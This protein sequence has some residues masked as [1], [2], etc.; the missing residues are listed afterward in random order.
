MLGNCRLQP[1]EGSHSANQVR[2]GGGKQEHRSERL[3]PLISVFKSNIKKQHGIFRDLQMMLEAPGNCWNSLQTA[4]ATDLRDEPLVRI[5]PASLACRA[6]WHPQVHL[7][8]VWVTCPSEQHEHCHP[9]TC[10]LGPSCQ[11]STRAAGSGSPRGKGTTARFAGGDPKMGKWCC[12]GKA[13]QSCRAGG[14]QDTAKHLSTLTALEA[15]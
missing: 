8:D 14:S 11:H 3:A 5:A 12:R 13:A 9:T 1:A 4:G 2:G 7:W 10:C 6:L 15:S